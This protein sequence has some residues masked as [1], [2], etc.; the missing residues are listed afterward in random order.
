[1]LVT[2][3]C[4]MRVPDASVILIRT[5]SQGGGRPVPSNAFLLSANDDTRT[6]HA[7]R[8]TEP[9]FIVFGSSPVDS[10]HLFSTLTAATPEM[11]AP[12]SV[13]NHYHPT[14]T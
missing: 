9:L 1:M 10:R 13:S 2:N 14:W 11:D 6:A 3:L 5:Q 12:V 4:R 8:L 7:P